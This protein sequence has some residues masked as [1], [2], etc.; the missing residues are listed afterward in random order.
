L[1]LLGK[2]NSITVI[3]NGR[4]IPVDI[5]PKFNRPALEIVMTKLHAGGKF[6]KQ[7]YKVSG[8]LHGVG[9][10]VVAALSK[11][12]KVIVKR[13]GKIY[14]QEYKIGKPLYDVK[15]TGECDKKETGTEVAFYPD[16]TIFSTIE[17]DFSTLA[18]RLREIAFL[19]KNVKIIL[20]EEKTKKKVNDK[21]KYTYK[22]GNGIVF[23]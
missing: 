2:D 14:K 18:T 19:N 20:E 5:H 13:G 16:S 23:F 1:F 4:G 17:F 12:M 8:G 22:Y 21:R 7:S 15:I 10:S 3:D 6:D 11:L 9:I